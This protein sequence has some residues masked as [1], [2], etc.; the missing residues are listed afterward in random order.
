MVLSVKLPT[1]NSQNTNLNN[2]LS[3]FK[4]ISSVQ[5]FVSNS[6]ALPSPLC[7]KI[8][9]LSSARFKSEFRH[10]NSLIWVQ[11]CYKSLGK[12]QTSGYDIK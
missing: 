4:Q 3:N 11:D 1:E 8:V 5:V 6:Q 10:L 7:S 9:F 12:P 2:M